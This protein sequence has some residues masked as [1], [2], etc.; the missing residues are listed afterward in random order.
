M[1]RTVVKQGQNQHLKILVMVWAT[2]FKG[3][4]ASEKISALKKKTN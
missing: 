3:E 4:T 2:K 1:D